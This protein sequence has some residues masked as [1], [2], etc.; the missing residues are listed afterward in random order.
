[1]CA[2][3]Y[4]SVVFWVVCPVAMETLDYGTLPYATVACTHSRDNPSVIKVSEYLP[5]TRH[6]ALNNSA[7]DRDADQDL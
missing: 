3:N 4:H 6:L 5:T 1:M 2:D 7:I